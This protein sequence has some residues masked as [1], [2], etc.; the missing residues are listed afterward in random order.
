MTRQRKMGDIP[1]G[2]VVMVEKEKVMP[3]P[4]APP[5]EVA[6]TTLQKLKPKKELSEKQKENLAKLV[7]RNKQRALERKGVI[8]NKIPEVIP[9]DKILLTVKPRRAY[10]KKNAQYWE[11]GKPK[12][13]EE[14]DNQ[15]EDESDG[16]MDFPPHPPALVRQDAHEAPKNEVVY[17][18]T[19]PKPKALKKVAP[20]KTPRHR[21]LPPPT[22]TETSDWSSE[23]SDS[24]EEDYRVNKYVQ[25]THKRM[26]AL[27]QIETQLNTMKNPYMARNMSIF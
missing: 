10:T 24:E 17:P 16:I 8:T 15:V 2:E 22:D 13:K 27:K 3:P 11:S 9:E 19:V 25:K 6:P 26:E 5:V 1:A 21:P 23:E 20:P 7:E 18:P 14:D 4:P 12:E